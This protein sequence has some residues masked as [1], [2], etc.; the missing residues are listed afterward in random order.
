MI[1]L[2]FHQRMWTLLCVCPLNKDSTTWKRWFCVIFLST[3]FVLN[4]SLV[5]SSITFVSEFWS[6]D[7]KGSL[8]ALFQLATHMGV[9]YVVIVQIMFRQR[10][11]AIFA[12][13]QQIYHKCKRF[14]S[15]V[16]KQE[17]WLSY[18]WITVY[19]ICISFKCR[20]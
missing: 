6:S 11:A 19:A 13:L 7:L 9:V 5:L 20:Y 4:V 12:Q 3:I 10:I 15:T 16:V 17:Y 8:H 2:A 1:P 14:S 18:F